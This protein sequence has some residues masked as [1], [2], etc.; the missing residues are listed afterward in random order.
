M[1]RV[2]G[3]PGSQRFW[4]AKEAAGHTDPR[5]PSLGPQGPAENGLDCGGLRMI[6]VH[7]QDKKR[8][9]MTLQEIALCLK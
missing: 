7:Q 5:R 4:R 3:E 6:T 9:S 1:S 8:K 2:G